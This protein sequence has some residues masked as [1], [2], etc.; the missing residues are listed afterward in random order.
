MKTKILTFIKFALFL[1]FGGLLLW[2]ALAGQDIEEM[3]IQIQ[4]A[5]YSWV[6]FSIILGLLSHLSRAI[7]WNMLIVP[8]G[9]KPKLYNTFF[10]V[11]IGYFANLAIPR[12]GEVTKCGVLKKYENIP[13]N[14]LIGTMIVERS[15]DLITLIL[16]LVLVVI[17]QFELL[18]QLFMDLI[19]QPLSE[20][21]ANNFIWMIVIIGSLLLP[22]VLIFVFIERIRKTAI[23]MKVTDL[24]IGM[25]EGIKSIKQME[26]KFL[27]LLHSVLIWGLYFLMAYVCFFAMD[28]TDHLGLMAGL[29]VL[30]FGSIG[31]VAPVQGGIGAYHLMVRETL[32]LYGIAEPAA[33]GF[34][35]IIHGA[36]TFILILFG[37]IS[38]ILLP[39]LNKKTNETVEVGVDTA[40]AGSA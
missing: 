4:E 33:K 39:I 37:F 3:K 8:L 19:F 18:N 31:M 25:W 38:L 30:A 6:A 1:A 27:F 16:I 5:D 23:Y 34:A 36:Q 24:L 12:L 13:V 15:V 17:T 22:V 9:Y 2:L 10:A 14:R 32:K 35:V 29:S 28:A 20:K 11:M 7:R 21:V 40:E 26:N